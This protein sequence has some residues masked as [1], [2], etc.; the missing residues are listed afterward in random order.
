MTVLIFSCLLTIAKLFGAKKTPHA[1]V[2]WKNQNHY[3]IKYSGA[4]DDNGMHPKQVKN[5]FIRL[6]VDELLQGKVVT[7][8][9]TMTIGCQIYFRK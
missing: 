1:F 4:I 6:A 2:I 3:E 8:N 9:E 5:E 7:I